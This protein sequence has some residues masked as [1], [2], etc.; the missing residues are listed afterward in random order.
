M[1]TITLLE[2]KDRFHF[3]FSGEVVIIY[4]ITIMNGKA[5]ECAS[6]YSAGRWRHAG[7]LIGRTI[8]TDKGKTQEMLT[9][10]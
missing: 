7:T 8:C 3:M 4:L 9:R 2:S 1:D 5:G 6:M 10:T